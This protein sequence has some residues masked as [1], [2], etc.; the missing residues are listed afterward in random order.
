MENI[1]VAEG[2]ADIIVRGEQIHSDD[3]SDIVG[4]IAGQVN[5]YPSRIKSGCK[6]E[7]YFISL[8]SQR[9]ARG[10]GHLT[11]RKALECLVQHM[12]GSCDGITKIAIIVTDSW[13]EKAFDDWYDNVE[14]IKRQGRIVQAYII[15]GNN[16]SQMRI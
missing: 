9:Y 2:I 7:A 12:Q 1:R 4:N 10:S 14:Q 3:I 11:F 16:V 6:H 15:S 5:C 8:R 13:D